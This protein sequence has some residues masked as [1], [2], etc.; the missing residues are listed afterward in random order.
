M[1][2]GALEGLKVL[3]VSR[4]VAGPFCAMMLG[5]LLTAVQERLP[6]KVAIFNN[7]ALDFV[8][9]E[10]KVEGLLEAYTDLVNPD[11]ARVAEAMGFWGRRV[12]QAEHLENV[13][14]A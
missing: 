13:L 8:E 3:D 2:G 7:S 9:I 10:Q 14:N 5:D 4:F 6:I 1:T 11:F 12:E